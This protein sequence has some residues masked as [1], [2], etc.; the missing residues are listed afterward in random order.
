[1]TRYY[2]QSSILVRVIKIIRIQSYVQDTLFLVLVKFVNFYLGREFSFVYENTENIDT[3]VISSAY[4]D[5]LSCSIR[6][7]SLFSQSL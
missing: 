5:V 6:Y 2:V 7:D 4:R 1:M 3:K